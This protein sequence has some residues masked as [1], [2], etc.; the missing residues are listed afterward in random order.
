MGI[1]G[2]GSTSTADF[3]RS[4][5]PSA[6]LMNRRNNVI[7]PTGLY[8]CEVLDSAGVFQSLYIGVYGHTGGE[9][10]KDDYR[11]QLIVMVYY[12]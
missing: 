3:S 5:R 11:A 4:R 1:A 2:S 6:V 8:R 9:H 12:L 7:S 10:V